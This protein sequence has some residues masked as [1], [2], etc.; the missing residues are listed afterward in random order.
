MNIATLQK[1]IFEL[2][3]VTQLCSTKQNMWKCFIFKRLTVRTVFMKMWLEDCQAD[4]HEEILI[5]QC[6]SLA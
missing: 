6:F 3:G 5:M 4:V 2:K 1:K